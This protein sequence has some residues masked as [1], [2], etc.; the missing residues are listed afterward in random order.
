[1]TRRAARHLVVRGAARAGRTSTATRQLAPR[2]RYDRPGEIEATAWGLSDT[3]CGPCPP[4]STRRRV[5][6]RWRGGQWTSRPQRRG[7]V[8]RAGGAE[9]HHNLPRPACAAVS[10][11]S[12]SSTCA[13]GGARLNS[14]SAE[15]RTAGRDRRRAQLK[16]AGSAYATTGMTR[17]LRAERT[18]LNGVAKRS[19]RCGPRRV[20]RSARTPCRDCEG[21]DRAGLAGRRMGTDRHIRGRSTRACA[22]LERWATSSAASSPSSDAPSTAMGGSAVV[23]SETFCSN[24]GE[25]RWCRGGA[26]RALPVPQ[27]GRRARRRGVR[28]QQSACSEQRQR[29]RRFGAK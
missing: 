9:R 1:M 5:R 8:R 20:Q 10:N 7:R 11:A 23:T 26:P 24:C 4:R 27:V 17:A 18:A 25:C 21:R 15:P 16:T 12:S 3:C 28:A 14:K 13:R 29:C 2:S 22:G 6:V 19:T